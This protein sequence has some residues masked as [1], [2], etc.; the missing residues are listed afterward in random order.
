MGY[1]YF[2]E[3]RKIHLKLPM[4][5]DYLRMPWSYPA[6]KVIGTAFLPHLNSR[7]MQIDNQIAWWAH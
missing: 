5:M 3:K 4:T 1:K 7:T 6:L 2:Q